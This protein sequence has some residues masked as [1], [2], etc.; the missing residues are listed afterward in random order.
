M[1]LH[2]YMYHCFLFSFSFGVSHPYTTLGMTV[3]THAGKSNTG[4]SAGVGLEYL[5]VKRQTKKFLIGGQI[6]KL[7]KSV[8]LEV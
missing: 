1:I 8:S 4:Y 6:D 7:R 3:N 5:T 2:I